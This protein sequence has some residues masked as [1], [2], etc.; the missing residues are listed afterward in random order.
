MNK[1]VAKKYLKDRK[2]PDI[3]KVKMA[4]CVKCNKTFASQF[5]KMR[6]DQRLHGEEDDNETI[7][8]TEKASEND[9][10]TV[11]DEE[12]YADE[13]SNAELPDTDDDEKDSEENQYVHD[14]WVKTI[15]E[16]VDKCFPGIRIPALLKEPVYSKFVN[17]LRKHMESKF[18]VAKT[19]KSSDMMKKIRDREDQ[20]Y[21]DGFSR[22][23]A[24]RKAWEDRKY[25]LKRTM[26]DVF[27]EP[28]PEQKEEP[29]Q[30]EEDNI[31]KIE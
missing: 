25:L 16:V 7:D 11:A 21:G 5:C 13:E 30:D 15:D 4:Y 12:Y 9:K 8:G 2:R 18:F 3:N 14:I 26:K 28:V 22:S 27:Y 17:K 29:E 1:A 23:E 10:E 19:L 20:L 24:K 31:A 6:H